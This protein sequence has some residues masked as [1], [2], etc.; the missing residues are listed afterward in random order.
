MKTTYTK[1]YR[2]I[3]FVMLIGLVVLAGCGGSKLKTNRVEGTVTQKGV[4]LAE[5]DITFYPV[6]AGA[7]PS[8]GKTD[9]AGKFLLQT[10]QGEAE[11][12]TTPG[13]YTVTVTKKTPVP[14]G[15]KLRTGDN[16]EIE[17][18]ETIL[19][20]VLPV[21]YAAVGTT[22]F[23]DIV[24]EDKKVNTFTFDLE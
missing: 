5:A 24:V 13:K 3:S 19:K 8:F 6:D 1:A 21:Q 20:D 2:L 15:R 9:V 4:P 22:P 11:A 10:L 16:F 14:T 7:T 12:G 18:D 17:Y 23:K